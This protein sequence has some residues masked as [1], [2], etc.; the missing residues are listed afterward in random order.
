MIIIFSLNATLL[1]LLNIGN[2]SVLALYLGTMFHNLTQAHFNVI[3]ETATCLRTTIKDE[4]SYSY[5]NVWYPPSLPG[6]VNIL[7][8]PTIRYYIASGK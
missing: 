1:F 4:L 6:L 7:L 3:D 2:E 8:C 5:S